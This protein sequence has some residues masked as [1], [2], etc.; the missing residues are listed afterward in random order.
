MIL[1]L[2]WKKTRRTGFVPAFL[3][4]GLLASLFPMVN[5]A[6]RSQ[7]FLDR[8][9]SPLQILMVENWQMMA[10]LN[11]LLVVAGTT[12]LYHT[13]YA[14]HAMEKVRALPIREGVVFL[15]K[16]LVTSL[17]WAGT[18]AIEGIAIAFCALHWFGAEL[19]ASLGGYLGFAYVMML[20]C[21]LL[22]LLISSAC[23]N[24]WVSLGIGVVCLFTAT[25]LPSDIFLCSLFPFAM[26]FQIYPEAV[27]AQASPYLWA[28]LAEISAI[29]LAEGLFLRLRRCF[30]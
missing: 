4:G 22:A 29:G 14:N 5:M 2:E 27:P 18:L 25:M 13:E 23:K 12:A 26:P 10:M 6:V 9:G 20:P 28:A 30:T 1:K 11:M 24:M 7:M 8:P 16:A 19:G 21:I 15:G 3:G 17:M